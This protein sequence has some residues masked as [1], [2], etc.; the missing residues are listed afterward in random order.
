[1]SFLFFFLFIVDPQNDIPPPSVV[2]A[3]ITHLLLITL[4]SRLPLPA[5]TKN[6]AQIMAAASA[7]AM[8]F[9]DGDDGDD[10]RSLQNQLAIDRIYKD[11]ALK[12]LTAERQ[13]VKQ[14][15]RERNKLQSALIQVESTLRLETNR[16]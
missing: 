12:E 10:K 6:S 13:K 15:T 5:P 16:Q 2:A 8:A 11:N 14:V 7:S 9:D 3:F 1:M 4:R